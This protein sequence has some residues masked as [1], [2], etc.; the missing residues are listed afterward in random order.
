M[1]TAIDEKSATKPAPRWDLDALFPGG[2]SSTEYR[3]FLDDIRKNLTSLSEGLAALPQQLSAE[4]RQ[5]YRD[6]ILLLQKTWLNLASASS[7][8]HCLVS[9]NTRD[10]KGFQLIDEADAM[11][12]D[13]MQFKSRLEALFA[14]QPDDQW[15]ELLADSEL[16]QIE[17]RLNEMRENAARK[18][19]AELEAL[20]QELAT[21]GYHAWSRLYDKL[22][23]EIEVAWE[24]NGE[25]KLLSIGQINSRLQSEDRDIRQKAFEKYEE[26]WS[27][28]ATLC[29]TTLNYQAGFR[30]SLYKRRGWPSA[31]YE[32]LK[33]NRLQ[34]ES[35]DAMW[36]ATR[37][38]MPQLKRFVDA[39]MKLLGIDKMVW[40]DQFAPLGHGG[41]KLTYDDA[42]DFI[43]KHLGSFSQ[44]MADFSKMAIEKRWIEAEDRPGKA[45]GGFCSGISAKGESRIFM[46]YTDDFNSM[47]TLAHELGH[48]YHHHV[49]REKPYLITEYPMGL[50]ETASIFNELRVTDAALKDVENDQ[51]KLMLLDQTLQ[52]PLILFCNI[53]ARYL[54]DKWFYEERARGT[55]AKERLCELMVAAQKEAFGDILDSENGYHPHF[56]ASK[57]H[58]FFTEVPFYNFPYTFGYL[59]AGGV[60]DVALRE[61]TAFAPKYRAL[62][63]DTGRMT[64]EEVA[65][66]HLAVDLTKPDFWN[67]AVKRS[68]GHLDEFVELAEKLS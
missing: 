35:L 66:K 9:Q 7:F 23:G 27:K 68:V 2:S 63:E 46:T 45:D 37:T 49:L 36:A 51:Q 39:K 25:T 50:A 60:Y 55:V 29:A 24:E 43:V 64:T 6:L 52:Q 16:K 26:A 34:Q 4:S 57:L 40:H 58:F 19:S 13:L 22:S 1:T 67:A 33:M 14:E 17:F 8:A 47:A 5:Q 44:E 12:G 18:M 21:N 59:F 62:L 10:T 42:S 11:I 20:A 15:K 56:W 3:K 53:Y 41:I 48:A 28:H 54:F 30:L 32:P 61:G 65:K 38:V 31:L